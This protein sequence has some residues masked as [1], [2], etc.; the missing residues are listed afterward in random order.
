MSLFAEALRDV[1]ER[2]YAFRVYAAVVMAADKDIEKKKR[3]EAKEG[4]KEESEGEK[5]E[6]E[7]KVSNDDPSIDELF[8]VQEEDKKK[9]EKDS[10]KK[11]EKVEL[12]SVVVKRDLW[13][14][15][16]YFDQNLCGSVHSFLVMITFLDRN[17]GLIMFSVQLY[18]RT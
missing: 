3:D 2:S 12:R 18:P 17:P 11:T 14:A 13:E 15:F 10:T 8:D 16:A 4:K 7:D 6:G 5:K 1:L 9:E